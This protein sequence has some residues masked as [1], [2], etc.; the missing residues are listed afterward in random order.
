MAFETLFEMESRSDRT[1]LDEVL[2]NR[3][4]DLEE[5]TE[6]SVRRDSV[7]FATELV[8][9]T[10]AHRGEIDRH[11]ARA[12]PAFPL[13]Q[14][15]L[16]DR[17]ALELAAF[18][19]QYAPDAPLKVVINEAVELGKTYGGENSGRFVNGVL[20]TI[21]GERTQE[22]DRSEGICAPTGDSSSKHNVNHTSRR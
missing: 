4:H 1:D 11:I 18:E 13:E 6:T 19:M 14:M 8:R 5:E 7:T 16:T 22:G 21:A 17:V 3:V 20:R 9:G 15:A 2:T 12:A 10:L